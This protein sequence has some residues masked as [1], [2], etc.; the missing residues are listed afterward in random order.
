MPCRADRH[1][2]YLPVFRWFPTP[3]P[4]RKNFRIRRRNK[5]VR[6]RSAPLAAAEVSTKSSPMANPSPR[7]SWAISGRAVSLITSLPRRSR[8]DPWLNCQVHV[9]ERNP[10]SSDVKF[11]SSP[12]LG[13][14]VSELLELRSSDMGRRTYTEGTGTSDFIVTV[15]RQVVL[16]SAIARSPFGRGRPEILR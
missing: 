15:M 9:A 13:S 8:N 14:P 3:G 6:Q 10:L 16:P 2:P 5:H 4:F 7:L 1:L 12:V 11:R